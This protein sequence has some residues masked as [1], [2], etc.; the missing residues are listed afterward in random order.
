M[1]SIPESEFFFRTTKPLRTCVFLKVKVIY[2]IAFLVHSLISWWKNESQSIILIN[3][4]NL[5]ESYRIP[6]KQ[7][8][9]QGFNFG[10][11]SEIARSLKLDI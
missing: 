7:N 10:I 2:K 4:L 6:Y 8:F 3:Y 11:F 1:L 9:E 5:R